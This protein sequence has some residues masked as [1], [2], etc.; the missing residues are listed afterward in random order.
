MSNFERII[1]VYNVSLLGDGEPE[2]EEEVLEEE[3]AVPE[4]EDAME[5]GEE[6]GMIYIY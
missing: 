1:Y 4:E 5:E 6:P 2:E 3:Q